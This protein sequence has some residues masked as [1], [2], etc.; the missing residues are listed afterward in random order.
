MCHVRH[1][2][3]SRRLFKIFQSLFLKPSFKKADGVVEREDLFSPLLCTVT[4]GTSRTIRL[5]NSRAEQRE[6]L[7]RKNQ[8]DNKSSLKWQRLLFSVPRI[9]A[10]EKR[11]QVSRNVKRNDFRVSV[12]RPGTQFSRAPFT[13]NRYKRA[14]IRDGVQRFRRGLWL[15]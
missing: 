3:A 15:A 13:L 10:S 12:R 9:L 11:R 6:R 5:S 1:A 7:F 14:S 8:Q 2:T 4:G